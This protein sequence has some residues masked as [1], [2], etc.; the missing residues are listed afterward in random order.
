MPEKDTKPPT[1]I[2]PVD[3][4]LKNNP[5]VKDISETS[6]KWS[7]RWQHISQPWPEAGTFNPTVIHNIQVLVSAHKADQKKGK[8]GKKNTKR[9]DKENLTCF[10]FLK[11][12]ARSW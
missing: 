11:M 1:E 9:R 4:V 2:T 7:R 8:K 5:L 3:V 6:K 10:S 12:R